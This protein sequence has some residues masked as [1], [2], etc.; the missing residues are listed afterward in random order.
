MPD[1]HL[2]IEDMIAEGDKVMRRNVWRWTDPFRQEDAV[3]RL[4]TLALR[5]RQ[6][7]RTLGYRHSAVAQRLN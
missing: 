7:R 3:P 4:R 5:S 6:D 2:T 1:L